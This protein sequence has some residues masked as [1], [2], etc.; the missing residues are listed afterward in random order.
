M[1]CPIATE[2]TYGH[3]Y[4]TRDEGHE[5]PCAAKRITACCYAYNGTLCPHD[6]A[7]L[8]EPVS[9][10]IDEKY[11]ILG[12]YMQQVTMEMGEDFMYNDEYDELFVM[13]NDTFYYASADAE[14]IPWEEALA[15]LEGYKAQ[16]EK[17]IKSRIAATD[18]E[19]KKSLDA[20]MHDHFYY[21]VDW[22]AKKRGHDPQIP[23]VKEKLD[24]WRSRQQ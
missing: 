11:K 9:M 10:T 19:E 14:T 8:G 21:L 15:L 24:E 3:F 7:R 18:P 12:L 4:C 23:Q 2:K 1:S 22:A 5:G 20:H 6:Q 17:F 13:L 16:W